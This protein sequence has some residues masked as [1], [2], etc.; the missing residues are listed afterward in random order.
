M[1]SEKYE[2]IQEKSRAKEKIAVGRQS[3]V[4]G[5]WTMDIE[6]LNAQ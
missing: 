1:D 5:P 3:S 4:N 2:N 6:M